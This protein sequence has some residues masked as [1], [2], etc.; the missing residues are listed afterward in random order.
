ML[1]FFYFLSPTTISTHYGVVSGFLTRECGHAHSGS[2]T[3]N[4][5]GNK[6]YSARNPTEHVP[7]VDQPLRNVA[8][9]PADDAPTV[10]H[11]RR[12]EVHHPT[13]GAT[14]QLGM[15]P[16]CTTPSVVKCINQLEMHPQCT[17]PS[18]VQR[19]SRARATLDLDGHLPC[20]TYP[21]PP[22][23]HHLPW[24]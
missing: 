7:P 23:L 13:E 18:V 20:T 15:H 17:T 1:F 24:T 10:D 21:A 2:R 5:V 9:Q 14:T 19:P 8:H 6:A 4:T 16:Q 11:A 3:C 22:T 12:I